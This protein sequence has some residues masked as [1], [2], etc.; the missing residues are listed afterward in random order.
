MP[1]SSNAETLQ[2]HSRRAPHG[3]G[4]VP[5]APQLELFAHGAEHEDPRAV[6]GHLSMLRTAFVGQNNP[7]DRKICEWLSQHTDLRLIIWTNE[8]AWSHG[9]GLNKIRK[10]VRRFGA[11]ARRLGMG[12]SADEFC[13][14][15]LYRLFF[16]RGEITKID[17]ETERLDCHPRTPLSAIRQVCPDAI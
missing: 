15:V 12:R 2:A 10:V 13:Y 17:L 6:S 7:F 1:R 14:Y 5:R 11:R 16:Y 9:H 8:L 4:H 3:G